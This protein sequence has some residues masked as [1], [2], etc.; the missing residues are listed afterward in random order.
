MVLSQCK[1]AADCVTLSFHGLIYF[2]LRTLDLPEKAVN[3]SIEKNLDLKGYQFTADR[4]QL[5]P[6][7]IVRVAVVQ[8]QIILPTTASVSEQRNAIFKRIEFIVKV[9]SMCGVNIICFQ[10]TW[11]KFFCVGFKH[12]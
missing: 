4:E 5:T 1:Y 7:R 10:E 12:L 6:P 11:S 8:N 9:A 2:M 3:L